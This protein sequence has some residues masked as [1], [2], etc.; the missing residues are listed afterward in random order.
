MR[1][2]GLDRAAPRDMLVSTNRRGFATNKYTAG[3]HLTLTTGTTY[4]STGIH[5]VAESAG[6]MV[7]LSANGSAVANGAPVILSFSVD[8]REVSNAVNGLAYVDAGGVWTP[9]SIEWV[10][11]QPKPSSTIEIVAKR[12][13]G[14]AAAGNL[15]TSGGVV[16]LTAMEF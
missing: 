3:S 14:T 1:R 12:G 7:R 8:G 9:F 11:E 2:L 15:L 4:V 13:G 6:G 5:V 16:V 10:I